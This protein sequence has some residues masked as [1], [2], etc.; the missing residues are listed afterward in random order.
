MHLGYP[1]VDRRLDL[2]FREV[3]PFNHF[4][5]DSKIGVVA[6]SNIPEFISMRA[7]GLPALASEKT[8]LRR[9][10]AFLDQ[11]EENAS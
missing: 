1:G 9:M 10:A 3:H 7:R 8:E 11:I 5:L 4:Q 2:S 6:V